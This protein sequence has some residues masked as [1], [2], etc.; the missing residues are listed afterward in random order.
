MLRLAW[1]A[2]LYGSIGAAHAVEPMEL[3][4]NTKL[5]Y[6]PPSSVPLSVRP[7][8]EFEVVDGLFDRLTEILGHEP[9]E[10]ISADRDRGLIVT[11][12]QSDPQFFVDC[13]LYVRVF[14]GPEDGFR[15]EPIPA[16]KAIILFGDAS[17]GEILE[18]HMELFGRSVVSIDYDNMDPEISFSTIY[19]LTK[20]LQLSSELT[21]RSAVEV[22]SFGNGERANFDDGLTCQSS[23]RLEELLSGLVDRAVQE[24]G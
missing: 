6:V 8:T 11:Q 3:S 13:G 14:P 5:A 23:G 18:R 7:P 19:A 4:P 24:N 20:R 12:F 21:D 2:A 16:S 17:R 9:F 10:I 1:I 15:V 22:V